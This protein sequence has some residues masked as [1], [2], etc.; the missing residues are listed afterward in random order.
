MRSLGKHLNLV[1]KSKCFVLGIH[2]LWL[3]PSSHVELLDIPSY[4]FIPRDL[5]CK[6]DGGIITYVNNSYTF[7]THDK[8]GRALNGNHVTCS[9][10]M[11]I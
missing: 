3:Q 9:E 11:Y 10:F 8:L 4:T 2:K 7:S 1:G 5:T 6:T